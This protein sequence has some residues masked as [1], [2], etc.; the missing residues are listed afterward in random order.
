MLTLQGRPL[1]LL[2]SG[3]VDYYSAA[4]FLTNPELPNLRANTL[5]VRRLRFVGGGLR[6]QIVVASTATRP[7][8]FQLRLS[9][10]TDFADL[11]EVKSSVRDRSPRIT[12]AHEPSAQKL[13]FGYEHD[14]FRVRTTVRETESAI[15]TGAPP[16]FERVGPAPPAKVDGDDFV[17]DLELQ[18]R[19]AWTAVFRVSVGV[20]DR[21]LEPSHEDFG[22][23]QEHEEGALTRWLAAVPQ[24]R[25]DNE[26]LQN[27]FQKSV[28]DLAALRVTGRFRDH[29]YV[30]PAA[31]LP[32]FMTL[33]GRDTIITAL[34]AL[35]VG[36][37][38]ARG[39]LWLLAALQGTELNGFRDEEP[40]KILH[41]I[42]QG[43]LTMLGEM[44]YSP[45][46]G[47]I[48]A[49]P[50]WI[51]LLSEYWRF[52]GDDEFIRSLWA[53]AVAAVRW[54]DE[55]GDRDG[56]GYV[57]YQT[58]SPEGLGNQCWKDSWDGIQFANGNLP[59]LPIATAET[60][61][62]VYDAKLRLA[63]MAEQPMGQA[64][65]ASRLRDEARDLG[66]RFERDYW[67]EERG[68]YFVVGLDGDKRQ[69]DS[70]TSNKGT[71]SGPGL[72]LR[73]EP[74][75]W[76]ATSSPTTCS[77]GGESGRCPDTTPATTRSGITWGRCGRMT[78]P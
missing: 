11:F 69:I 9:T 43:E 71:C 73:I 54:M 41:E 60:Q 78:M 70:M 20:D 40:G 63:E 23:E 22:E 51:I 59:Y 31:G 2:K 46:Y 18:P 65:L 19:Q 28:L 58:R 57:E 42:R 74:G 49:T 52:S 29:D 37:E 21:V 62:Y 64:D 10:G 25:S 61:G 7:L 30:L 76:L 39:A 50:L 77:R 72:C 24:F 17:W 8:R 33:F 32:W 38:L 67:S 44:P 4:F 55:H 35:W 1:S 48:D 14:D 36:P 34:E 12:R 56:D 66:D 53:N 6:E 16:R 47:T 75:S 27:V 5:S 15:L 68:G 3:V 13:A 26:L 45:Y